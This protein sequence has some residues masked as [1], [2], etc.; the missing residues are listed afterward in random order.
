MLQHQKAAVKSGYWPL[1]RYNPDLADQGK[2]PLQIDS[3]APSMPV[4]E[5]LETENRFRQVARRNPEVAAKLAASL[6]TQIDERWAMLEHLASEKS[7][8]EG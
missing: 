1:F 5:Y 3:K 8:V 7:S 6:Q 4:Q 2:N